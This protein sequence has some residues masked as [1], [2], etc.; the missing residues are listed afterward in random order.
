MSFPLQEFFP[1]CSVMVDSHL[2]S[3]EPLLSINLTSKMNGYRVVLPKGVGFVGEGVAYK[4]PKKTIL[5][6]I[7]LIA[8]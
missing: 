4:S 3:L 2:V 1:L 6:S 5:I 7:P 8:K